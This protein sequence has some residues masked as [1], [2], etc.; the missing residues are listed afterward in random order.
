M[1]LGRGM[2]GFQVEFFHKMRDAASEVT[3][4]IEA[5]SAESRVFLDLAISK[6]G[7]FCTAGRLDVGIY[8]KPTSLVHL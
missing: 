3:F 7:D 1:V 2:R 6:S 8:C 5:V 4:K